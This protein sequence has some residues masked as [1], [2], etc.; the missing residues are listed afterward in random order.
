MTQKNIFFSII[1]LLI[2][3][4]L[5]VIFLQ[6]PKTTIPST[7]YDEF[8][9]CLASQKLTMY[10][11]VW[12]SHCQAQKAL[13]GSSFQYVPYVE[14]TENPDRCVAEGITGYPKWIDEK[15]TKYEGEQSLEKLGEISGCQLPVN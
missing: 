1:G 7:K 2:L 15:G 5:G 12:C 10:G 8:A 14:C 4:T 6:P 9:Q 11:A 13:F 3:G